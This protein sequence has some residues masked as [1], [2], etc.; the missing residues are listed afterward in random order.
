[1]KRSSLSSFSERTDS[2]SADPSSAISRKNALSGCGRT[3]SS[4]SSSKKSVSSSI[5]KYCSVFSSSPLISSVSKSN[6]NSS[7]S[8]SIVVLKSLSTSSFTS[9]CAFLE[10]DFTPDSDVFFFLDKEDFP[11][12]ASPMVTGTTFFFFTTSSGPR[13]LIASSLNLIPS[14]NPS[15]SPCSFTFLTGSS[16]LS[17][18]FVNTSNAKSS[19][20][21]RASSAF[22]RSIGPFLLFLKSCP[23]SCCCSCSCCLSLHSNGNLYLMVRPDLARI[24]CSCC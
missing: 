1:M 21:D 16:V 2:S 3:L 10:G 4:I 11:R 15:T 12:S 23:C 5:S 20:S 22:C 17:I 7:L 18:K 9:P 19:I 6:S 24:S 8:A 14:F 13:F